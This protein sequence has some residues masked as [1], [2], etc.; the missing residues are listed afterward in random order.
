MDP[1]PWVGFIVTGVIAGASLASLFVVRRSLETFAVAGGFLSVMVMSLSLW[2]IATAHPSLRVLIAAV[3]LGVGAFVGGFGLVSALLGSS[4]A[5]NHHEEV[6]PAPGH[7]SIPVLV[8][9]DVEPPSYCPG[10]VTA[11]IADLVAA[12]IPQAGIGATPFL[13]AAH[14]ARYRA[15]GDASP[16]PDQARA[17]C[18][19]IESHLD[20]GRFGPV[21]LVRCGDGTVLASAVASCVEQGQ[22]SI[23]IATIHIAETFRI[24]RE[25]GGVTGLHLDTDEVSIGYTQPLWAS[26][27]LARI[28][29]ARVLEVTSEPAVTGVA[30]VMHGQPGERERTHSTFD[31][32]ENAFANRVK[33]MLGEAGIPSEYIRTCWQDW[34]APDVTET[35]RHLA[36]LACS[37]IV[38]SPAC[39]PLENLS[40]LLDLP[41]AIRQARVDEDVS[42]V[43]VAPWRDDDAVAKVIVDAITA[44]ADETLTNP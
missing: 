39:Y 19:R 13:Y 7:V 28:A 16:E 18:E 43:Q 4:R 12:G 22:C 27:V 44:V 25:K 15:V 41:V 6:L 26:D 29:A 23:I 40:T 11:E 30:L 36:A 2:S 31:V 9:A 21:H 32:Q 42:V 24:D 20:P 8:L 10:D 35:V 34:R 17:L 3:T 1:L 37:R 14:K 38:V 33:L 5:C